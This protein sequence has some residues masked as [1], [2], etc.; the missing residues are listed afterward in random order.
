MSYKL[1]FNDGTGEVEVTDAFRNVNLVDDLLIVTPIT[2]TLF[3]AGATKPYDTTPL[4]QPIVTVTGQFA[5][6]EG[7]TYNT[8]ASITEVG[9]VNNTLTYTRWNNTKAINYNISAGNG[10]LVITDN[11][12]AL[13]IAAL[14]ATA[15]YSGATLTAGYELLGTIPAGVASVTA[16]VA[17][18]QTAAGT[19]LNVV[20]GYT[21]RDRNGNDVT[22]RY[23]NV[24]VVNGSLTVYPRP[25]TITAGSATKDYDGDPIRNG[26]YRISGG[27][28]APGQRLSNVNVTGAQTEV[29]SSRNVPSGAV[30]V[31]AAG[32]RVT[33]NYRVTY[34]AGLLTVN[35]LPPEAPPEEP[36]A[37]EEVE[38]E[39]EPAPLAEEPPAPPDDGEET[40]RIIEP[41]PTPLADISSWA[42]LNLILSILGAILAIM[43]LVRVLMKRRK[44]ED[45]DEQEEEED[46]K[47]K[48]G[49]I[50][51]ILL[52]PILAI[53]AFIIFFLTQDMTQPMAW[54]DWW[55]LA[56]AILF[57]GGI[58]SYIFA[59][60]KQKQDKDEDRGNLETQTA[61]TV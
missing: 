18:A 37:P 4:T 11:T 32:T 60:K 22:S 33:A 31:N 28:L 30:I 29:G 7:V 14:S 15:V 8:P 41:A 47:E 13:T 38:I 44:D 5:P 56:H 36:P 23:N 20:T 48:R 58:L 45:E 49:R 51:L 40:D 26:T 10:V 52:I 34:G 17:G 3:R 9:S 27:S 42:L 2:I 25:I 1:W 53:V 39:E 50:P 12:T 19:T 21:L 35:G 16:T 6:N 43:M 57:I 55:T 46:E 54:I 59:Y 24:N 61:P